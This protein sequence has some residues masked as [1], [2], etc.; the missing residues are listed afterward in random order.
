MMAILASCQSMAQ[1]SDGYHLVWSEE[2]NEPYKT[3]HVEMEL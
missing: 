3:R 1:E 2:F